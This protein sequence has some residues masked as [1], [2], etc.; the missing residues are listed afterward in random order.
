MFSLSQSSVY[1]NY[2]KFG[3]SKITVDTIGA[4][5]GDYDITITGTADPSSSNSVIP[6]TNSTKLHVWIWR[7]VSSLP[8]AGFSIPQ[9]FLVLAGVSVLLIAFVVTKALLSRRRAKL[10]PARPPDLG[11]GEG[12]T[13]LVLGMGNQWS[14]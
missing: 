2:T 3:T 14:G 10:E 11:G 12:R 13:E 8:P 6:L 5:L 1:T 9:P 4:Q 7:G